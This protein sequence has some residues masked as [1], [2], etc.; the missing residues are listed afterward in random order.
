MLH[1]NKI[2]LCQYDTALNLPC[3]YITHGSPMAVDLLRCLRGSI[4]AERSLHASALQHCSLV[5]LLLRSI[6]T[7][8]SCRRRVGELGNALGSPEWC[9]AR[10]QLASAR[11]P[12]AG[13]CDGPAVLA[14]RHSKKLTG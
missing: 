10:T 3:R 11:T 5:F 9:V 7:A 14:K 2:S 4:R 6:L 12:R 8:S 1:S 13:T